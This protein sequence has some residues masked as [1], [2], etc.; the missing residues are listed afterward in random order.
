MLPPPTCA[1]LTLLVMR[2]LMTGSHSE[3]YVMDT[4]LIM[5]YP[6]PHLHTRNTQ[7]CHSLCP[8]CHQRG[9]LNTSKEATYC[10]CYPAFFLRVNSFKQTHLTVSKGIEEQIREPVT[11]SLCYSYIPK[12]GVVNRQ[13]GNKVFCYDCRALCA[14]CIIFM[15]RIL[16]DCQ[17][18]GL[19]VCGVTATHSN[20]RSV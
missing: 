3:E 18:A 9:T 11:M 16:Y 8:C 5:H 7:A 13:G 10:Q 1:A 6:G 15:C 17:W 12:Y 2:D 4:F 20:T 14:L 19:C